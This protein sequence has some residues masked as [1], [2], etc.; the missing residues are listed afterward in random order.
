MKIKQIAAVSA[1][2]SIK[3]ASNPARNADH[4]YYH[5]GDRCYD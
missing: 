4:F 1:A 5:Q 2:A 3:K